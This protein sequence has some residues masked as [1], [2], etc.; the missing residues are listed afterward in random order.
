MGAE[1]RTWTVPKRDYRAPAL[2]RITENEDPNDGAKM[3]IN[4]SSPD[5]DERKIL[6]A[7]FLELVRLGMTA[8]AII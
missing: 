3:E 4:S 7:G 1:R 2:L 8:R 5:V 6:D